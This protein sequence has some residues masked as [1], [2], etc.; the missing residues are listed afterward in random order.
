MA[1]AEA[2]R[3]GGTRKQR[4]AE[5]EARGSRGAWHAQGKGAQTATKARE[6]VG[7]SW[8][9]RRRSRRRRARWRQQRR[10]EKE[11]RGNR[12]A[13]KQRRV[14]RAR[15]RGGRRSRRR[16][17]PRLKP[18][19]AGGPFPCEIP[20][21]ATT[22]RVRVH[23]ASRRPQHAACAPSGPLRRHRRQKIPAARPDTFRKRSRWPGGACELGRMVGGD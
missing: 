19:L 6:G 8:R 5:A 1:A 9:A 11:A 12:G 21:A 23:P 13:R 2:R 10:A 4:C 17:Q 20:H 16:R 7:D 14:T 3:N 15:R 18:C 22:E